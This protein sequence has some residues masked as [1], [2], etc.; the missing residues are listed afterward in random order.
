MTIMIPTGDLCGLLSDVL[1]F[2]A[3]HKDSAFSAIRLEWDG[4]LLH[5]MATDRFH[6]AWA[7]WHPDD[8]HDLPRED[9]LFD[10]F[11]GDDPPWSAIISA[12]D[13]EHVRTTFK[14][15]RKQ[16]ATALTLELTD[17]GSVEVARSHDTGYA[18]LTERCPGLERDLIDFRKLLSSNDVTKKVSALSF[19]AG[20]LADF[21]AVRQRGPMHMLFTKTIAHVSIGDRFVGAIMPIHDE[22]AKDG[23]VKQ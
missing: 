7:S 10:H 22:E 2:A 23:A 4:N 8:E 15:G 21:A 13:A 17:D 12:A 3:N 16:W 19:N 6:L 11:G 14:L 5:A 9:S 1:P 18:A 20:K